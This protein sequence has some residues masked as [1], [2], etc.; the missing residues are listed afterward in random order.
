MV[1][2]DSVKSMAFPYISASSLDSLCS[3]QLPDIRFAASALKL[4]GVELIGNC[5]GCS[6]LDDNR[7]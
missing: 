4:G 2:I 3:I 6:L 5:E 1:S 7:D